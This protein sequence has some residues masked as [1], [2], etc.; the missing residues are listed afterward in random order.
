MPSSAELS[1]IVRPPPV[2]SCP[3]PQLDHARDSL[4]RAENFHQTSWRGSINRGNIMARRPSML[5]STRLARA[6]GLLQWEAACEACRM[7]WPQ[8]KDCP[9]RRMNPSRRHS[10][11]SIRLSGRWRSSFPALPYHRMACPLQPPG[12]VDP[13]ASMKASQKAD[14]GFKSTPLI[15]VRQCRRQ[16]RHPARWTYRTHHQQPRHD[17]AFE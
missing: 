2:R 5:D 1:R 4:F 6:H 10:G 13:A 17:I 15:R 7:L 16:E 12:V 3:P 9:N 14:T 11:S 8:G